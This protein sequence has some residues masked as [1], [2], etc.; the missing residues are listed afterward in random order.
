[1]P[2]RSIHSAGSPAPRPNR[3]LQPAFSDLVA[4][5][6]SSCAVDEGYAEDSEALFLASSSGNG[7]GDP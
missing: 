1:L 6:E 5:S 7:A 3:P 4:L 2:V